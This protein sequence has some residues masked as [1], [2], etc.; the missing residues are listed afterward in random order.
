MIRD[1]R[2][3]DA[4]R[5]QEIHAAQ[6]FD[7][8]LPDMANPIFLVKKVREEN[9]RIVGALALR[10]TAETFLLVDGGAFEKARSI[11]ELQPEVVAEAYRKGLSDIVCVVPP[12]IAEDFGPV[13][14]RLGWARDRDWPMYSRSVEI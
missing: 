7:Y 2:P 11:E 1:Y 4:A 6:G 10:V 12:D 13:M 9:G 8:Q 3:E 5:L 14:E